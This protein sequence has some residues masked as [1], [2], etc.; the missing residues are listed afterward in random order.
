[1]ELS[2]RQAMCR[3]RGH[4]VHSGQ[5]RS[6]CSWHGPC[7]D[8]SA[9]GIGALLLLICHQTCPVGGKQVCQDCQAMTCNHQAA[10][11]AG[12]HAR[13]LA[14]PQHGGVRSWLGPDLRGHTRG[15]AR[16]MGPG[17]CP[18]DP[19]STH[20]DRGVSHG[21]CSGDRG[22]VAKDASCES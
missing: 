16:S 5:T 15:Q 7:H 21:G 9:S 8:P 18:A 6:H 2:R 11:E 19:G 14:T 22:L 4:E 12:L 3:E 1:M 13:G 17:P 10:A 20:V